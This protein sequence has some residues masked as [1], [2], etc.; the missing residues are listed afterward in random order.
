MPEEADSSDSD[1][2]QSTYL[3][4]MREAYSIQPVATVKQ[5][6]RN[7]F[8][9]SVNKPLLMNMSVDRNTGSGRFSEQEDGSEFEATEIDEFNSVNS[10]E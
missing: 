8:T 5:A 7:I 4:K 2:E 9:G 3:D 10:S 6:T 1:L